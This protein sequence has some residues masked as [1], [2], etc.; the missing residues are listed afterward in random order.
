MADVP[1]ISP[2]ELDRLRQSDGA[3][4]VDVRRGSYDESGEKIQGAIRVDPE[5][6]EREYSRIPKGSTVVTYCT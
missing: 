1:R 6:Y 2:E 4:V 3:V 5:S